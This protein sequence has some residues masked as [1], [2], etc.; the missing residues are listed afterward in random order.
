[1]TFVITVYVRGGIVMAAD[2]RLTLNRRVPELAPEQA[3]ERGRQQEGSPVAC[4]C[5]V[6]QTDY[7]DKL[8]LA[9]GNIGISTWGEADIEG[10]PVTAY[11]Q[12]F[13]EEQLAGNV[14]NVDDIPGLLIG[15]FNAFPKVPCTNFFVAGYKAENGKQVQHVYTLNTRTK[16]V[17]RENMPNVQCAS[18][19]GEKDIFCRLINPLF[20]QSSQGTYEPLP[21]FVIPW[22]YF[23]LQD[24]IDFALFAARTTRDTMRFQQRAQ[25]VG[26]PVDV[27]VIKPREA[28]WVQQKKLHV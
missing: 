1:M 17:K 9:P 7:H 23:T 6:G 18:W 19:A 25:T 16:T 11:V 26:G 27:L 28:I 22:Q 5:Q 14:R 21:T 2:S 13:I 12:A 8:F 20:E 24:A 4:Q 15:Y 10:V 3:P